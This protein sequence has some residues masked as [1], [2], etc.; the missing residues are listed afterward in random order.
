VSWFA[1]GTVYQATASVGPT[2]S[3]ADRAALGTAFGSMMFQGAQIGGNLTPT[4]RIDRI[5]AQ[6]GSGNLRAYRGPT[7]RLCVT[8][9][10]AGDISCDLVPRPGE[11]I[12][13]GGAGALLLGT[14]PGVE[15][16]VAGA[17]DDRVLSVRVNVGAGRWV[18]A[19]IVTLPSQLEFPYRLFYVAADVAFPSFQ[20]NNPYPVVARDAHG[21]VVGRSSYGVQGG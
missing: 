4:V 6:G 9:S 20:F 7:G 2:A 5:H 18:R 8:V 11:A 1:A 10:T 19:T 13:A 21:V 16:F 3:A 15:I 14:G 17:V 12:H